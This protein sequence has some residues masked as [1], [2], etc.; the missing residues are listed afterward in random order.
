[1]SLGC[2]IELL[3]VSI[4]GRIFPRSLPSGKPGKWSERFF[5]MLCTLFGILLRKPLP[6][7]RLPSAD[8]SVDRFLGDH[9]VASR[10]ANKFMTSVG[11]GYACACRDGFIS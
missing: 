7:T 11:C 10:C 3:L 8:Q 9:N 5:E 6:A 2:M 4:R 1:M